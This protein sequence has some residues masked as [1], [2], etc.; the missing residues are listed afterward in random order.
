MTQ[1]GYDTASPPKVLVV[2]DSK[3]IVA[4]I[5][6]LLCGI[7]YSVLKVYDGMEG[8]ETALRELPD[9]IILDVM[10]PKLDG[11]TVCRRLKENDATRLI[12][13]V[14]LTS[15]DYIDDKING[16]ESGASDY[17]TKPFDTKEF[18]A[19][20]KGIVARKLY[21]HKIAEEEKLGALSMMLESIAHEVR[22]PITA[23]GGFARRIRDRLPKGDR[24]GVYAQHI[25]HE[26]ER[27]EGML[28]EIIAFKTVIVVPV[29]TFGIEGVVDS[30]LER[31]ADALESTD[32]E[33]R[34]DYRDT[35]IIRGG[36]AKNIKLAFEN[37]IENAADAMESGGT[38][39]AGIER[40]DDDVW[41]RFSD[42]GHGIPEHEQSQITRP[43]YTSKMSGAGMGLPL[44][45]H[46]VAMHGGTMRIESVPGEGTSVTMVLPIQQ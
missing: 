9:L 3:A 46:I 42:T 26:V 43:F 19:R 28:N 24:L 36:D 29:E 38:L 1:T 22:N 8:L 45:Q 18:I 23:I 40:H 11:L 37:L 4:L 7:G 41:I 12:P 21:R 13:V 16:L 27:L 35:V 17:I 20:I 39:T 14:L 34:R 33:V 25:V 5:E 44:V 6:K 10:M 31:Y 32:I 2:D 30:A 15:K